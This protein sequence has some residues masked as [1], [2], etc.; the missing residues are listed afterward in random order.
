[1]SSTEIQINNLEEEISEYISKLNNDVGYYWWQR[2]IYSAFGAIFPPLLI[3]AF[4]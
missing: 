2:Y 4:C 1:M 3:F